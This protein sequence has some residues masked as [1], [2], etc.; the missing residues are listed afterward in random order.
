MFEVRRTWRLPFRSK[1]SLRRS[2]QAVETV[3]ALD[4]GLS[5]WC[6]RGFA[7]SAEPHTLFFYRFD[8]PEALNSG[9]TVL[10]FALNLDFA[11]A[12]GGRFLL[13]A[14]FAIVLYF[15]GLAFETAAKKVGLACELTR[16]LFHR[17]MDQG[18]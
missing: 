1:L 14:G 9:V 6:F 12:F 2:S 17:A 18:G 16:C 5:V 15:L 4:F 10:D 7:E 13:K 11:A 8:V 3:H